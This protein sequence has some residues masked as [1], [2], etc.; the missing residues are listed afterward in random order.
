MKLFLSLAFLLLGNLMLHATELHNTDPDTSRKS[1]KI[2]KEEFIEKYAFDDS[3]KMLVEYWFANR[4][5]GFFST[6]LSA[7]ASLLFGSV[8]VQATL[9]AV[10]YPSVAIAAGFAFLL[11]FL[12]LLISYKHLKKYSRKKLYSLLQDYQSGKPLPE[13]HVA[14]IRKFLKFTKRKSH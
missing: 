14:G 7:F 9:E 2:N 10:A 4:G 8:S 1:W 12:I 11:C 13:K 3:S 5:A 6:S